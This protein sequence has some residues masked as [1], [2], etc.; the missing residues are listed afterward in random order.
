MNKRLGSGPR[1]V[2]RTASEQVK[3]H[4]FSVSGDLG[5]V[6]CSSECG[7]LGNQGKWRA[8]SVERPTM[9][10]SAAVWLVRLWKAC[11]SPWQV[12]SLQPGR[13]QGIKTSKHEKLKAQILD[14]N[15]LH[16]NLGVSGD[17]TPEMRA[18]AGEVKME[19]LKSS[20]ITQGA[21]GS[22]THSTY[23]FPLQRHRC[24]WTYVSTAGTPL[25]KGWPHRTPQ[26]LLWVLRGRLLEPLCHTG[27]HI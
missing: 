25:T 11:C 18:K 16:H 20:S 12:Q 7:T 13:L 5:H 21:R 19:A 4:Q 10:L 8:V 9:G 27:A 24:G 17:F 23:S 2:G 22:G 14:F 26:R 3:G 1:H 6:S 15:R